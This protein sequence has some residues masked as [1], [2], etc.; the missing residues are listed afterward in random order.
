MGDRINWGILLS[1]G[2][3][4]ATAFLINTLVNGNL[5]LDGAAVIYVMM[6]G[7]ALVGF[8]YALSVL[9]GVRAAQAQFDELKKHYEANEAAFIKFGFPR[10]FGN[11]TNHVR[12]N[13][14]AATLPWMMLACWFFAALLES[15]GLSLVVLARYSDTLEGVL[16]G[17]VYP[18]VGQ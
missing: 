2:L 14:A 16:G 1:G 12:G 13:S 8:R 6:I 10:P 11:D 15:I 3:F 18:Y 7:V 4:T 5:T 9:G 17:L